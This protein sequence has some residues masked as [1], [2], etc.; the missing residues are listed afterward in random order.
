MKQDLLLF[1]RLLSWSCQE[2]EV[3]GET[4]EVWQY[5]AAVLR[6]AEHISHVTLVV[7]FGDRKQFPSAY[8][9]E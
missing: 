8:M 7:T 4:G 3:S 9:P 1:S 5:A 2:I 6:Q